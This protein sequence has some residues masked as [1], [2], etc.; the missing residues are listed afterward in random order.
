MVVGTFA[1]VSGRRP[2]YLICFIVYI[3]ANIGCALSPNY[4]SLLV[5]RMIQSAGS[6]TTVA[7]VQ[8]VVADLVTS[9]ERGQYVGMATV[10]IMLAPAL[11]PVLGGIIAQFLGWRWIFWILTILA[12]VVCLMM[13]LFMPETCRAIVGDGSIAPPV[14]YRTGYDLIK[15]ALVKRR[16]DRA[17]RRNG[18]DG[19]A[20]AQIQSIKE[21]RHRFA[22]PNPLTSLKILVEPEIFLLL[23]YSSIVG[24]GFYAIYGYTDL[25]VGLI[26]LPLAAG[27]VVSSIFV[28]RLLNWNYR[29][30][31]K[32]QGLPYDSLR[33]Q[34]LS[35]FPIER[36]RLE[37]TMP[38]LIL[39]TVSTAAWGWIVQYKAPIAVPCVVLFIMGIA[40][41]GFT[42]T[43]TSLLID[44]NQGRAAAATAANNITRCL[45]GAAASAAIQ[46]MISAV[47]NGWAFIILAALFV[48][49][50][51]A[52]IVIMTHGLKW[53][54]WK[55]KKAKTKAEEEEEE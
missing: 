14:Y 4:V 42:N 27:C 6:S 54:Q 5:V 10:P 51:P 35:N 28:G 53:R 8:G 7:L 19:E 46:P 2:A 12:A 11:G 52:L 29:R 22:M 40:L 31:C 1:D 33:Q 49:G 18:S 21:Q 24:A 43:T 17:R 34:D 36:A 39:T 13:A 20:L 44:L 9:A 55:A 48:G 37:I 50:S 26:Y 32:Q 16:D 30:H 3:G 45:V 25:V 15:S 41:I 47:G 23:T 38:S